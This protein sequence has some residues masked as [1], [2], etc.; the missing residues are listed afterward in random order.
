[1]HASPCS[2]LRVRV[3]VTLQ[4]GAGSLLHIKATHLAFTHGFVAGCKVS[5][6]IVTYQC[7]GKV[8]LR[9]T[10]NWVGLG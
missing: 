2:E 10:M 3:E 6:G 8:G 7:G 4:L 5:A 1:M 9:L